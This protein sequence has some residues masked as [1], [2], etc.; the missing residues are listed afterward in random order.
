M[1]KHLLT[2]GIVGFVLGLLM[3]LVLWAPEN[4]VSTLP[5]RSMQ[6]GSVIPIVHATVHDE[7]P[8]K[9][10]E[11]SGIASYYNRG[12][13]VLHNTVYGSTCKM[14]NGEV[15]D[16]QAMIAACPKKLLGKSIDVTNAGKTITVRCTDTGSFGEK[17]KRVLDLSQ[18]AFEQLAPKSRGIIDVTYTVRGDHAN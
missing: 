15:F 1:K 10:V 9:P 18:G 14:R 16:D 2:V 11:V 5:V 4:P 8:Q 12:I 6:E 3:S 7:K 17:Y 13:C